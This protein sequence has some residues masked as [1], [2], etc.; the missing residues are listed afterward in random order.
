MSCIAQ[1]PRATTTHLL[2]ALEAALPS[3]E[4][5]TAVTAGCYCYTVRTPRHVYE[6]R[7]TQKACTLALVGGKAPIKVTRAK[8]P[9]IVAGIANLEV[10]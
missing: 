8:V 3:V 6:V 4:I 2:T 7:C 10:N 5:A 9:A 1:R